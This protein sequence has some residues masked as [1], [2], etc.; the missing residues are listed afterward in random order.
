MPWLLDP[1]RP[2]LH[3]RTL[4]ELVG[5]PPSSPAVLRSRGG[6]NAAGPVASL[7]ED[8]KPDGGWATSAGLWQVY[9][10]PG[11]RLIAAVQWGADPS[12]PRL[13]AAAERLLETAPGEGG[14]A[15]RAGRAA[16]A[17]LTARALGAFAELGWCRH[18]RF[19][20]GLAWLAEAAPASPQGGWMRRG[21]P[22]GA[23]ECGVTAVSV[24]LTLAACDLGS[25]SALRERA[26]SALLRL[27][28]AR[29]E[30]ADRIG[31]PCLGRTDAVEILWALA[32]AGVPLR[33]EMIPAL[34]ALQ[35]LQD[36]G[37]R[38]RRSV[39]VPL[40]LHISECHRDRA[41]SGWLTLKAVVAL[42]CYAVEAGLERLYPE[43]P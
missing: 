7:L 19:Q 40:S 1:L 36:F 9:A 42:M 34:A 31:H 35:H 15:P 18:V 12:D 23:T 3:W 32:R 25:R 2:N 30:K 43:K 24:L 5:R 17:W 14:F 27:L 41:P 26:V 38:W 29:M 11:W 13:Q 20:E 37:A 33:P 39:P 28:V 22:T 4:V 8:L 10:G 16:E 21:H 6:A